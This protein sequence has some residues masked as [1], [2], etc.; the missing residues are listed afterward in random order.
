MMRTIVRIPDDAEL[1]LIGCICFGL[2]DRGTNLIQ[3]RPIS[4]CN[5]NCIFCSVDE[6]PN[7][8]TRVTSYVVDLDYL[9]EWFI[10]I[11][12]FKGNKHIEAHIDGTGEP[13]LYPQLV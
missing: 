11:A 2:I 1:P 9:M 12:K 6:G 4:G 10:E 13:T 8:K 5:L 7:S 3:V